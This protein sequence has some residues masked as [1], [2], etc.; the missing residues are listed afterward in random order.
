ML[1][2]GTNSTTA[3]RC[4]SHFC[5]RLEKKIFN[6][7][8]IGLFKKKK[9]KEEL[10]RKTHF[11]SQPYVVHKATRFLAASV[12]AS[13]AAPEVSPW[14]KLIVMGQAIKNTAKGQRGES[15]T[16][17]VVKFNWEQ[18]TGNQTEGDSEGCE[19]AHGTKKRKKP[20]HEQKP[21]T[22]SFSW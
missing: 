6:G 19:V 3:H 17:M 8:K 21:R 2:K 1:Q 10:I 14:V 16:Q 18:K 15:E 12:L 9:K 22:V 13:V 4:H 7:I 11:W 20:E 5:S